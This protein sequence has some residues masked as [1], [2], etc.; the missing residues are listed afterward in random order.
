MLLDKL[1]SAGIGQRPVV[2]VTHRSVN[3]TLFVLLPYVLVT[4]ART[5]STCLNLEVS[6]I[7]FH[8]LIVWIATVNH[9]AAWVAWL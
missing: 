9:F 1:I 8:I 3:K 2:F 7:Y 5:G 6:H 4:Q